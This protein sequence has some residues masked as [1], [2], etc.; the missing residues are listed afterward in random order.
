MFAISV[1]KSCPLEVEPHDLRQPEHRRQPRLLQAPLRQL[2]RRGVRPAPRRPLLRGPQPGQRQDV[3]EVARSG[4]KDIEMA[5]DAAHKAKGA[6]GR[7][8][9]AERANILNKI[10]DRMEANLEMLA[11]AEAWENG[12]PVRETLAADV[13]LAIAH[14]RALGCPIIVKPKSVEVNGKIIR[15]G[16]FLGPDGEVLEFFQHQPALDET[17]L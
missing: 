10:A 4:A 17:P 14:V 1:R 9:Q 15:V 13:P 16:F 12:K 8:S 5:L 11:V 3:C 7:T 6:W 2:H